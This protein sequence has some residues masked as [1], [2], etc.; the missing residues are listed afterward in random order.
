MWCER[1]LAEWALWAETALEVAIPML[2]GLCVGAQQCVP[3]APTFM[4]STISLIHSTW[5]HGSNPTHRL[6]LATLAFE[7][8]LFG[9]FFYL[10]FYYIY[11]SE[12]LSLWAHQDQLL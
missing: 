2:A 11:L 9:I 7:S 10:L 3:W 5:G 4:Y 6:P 8:D 12:I 1:W